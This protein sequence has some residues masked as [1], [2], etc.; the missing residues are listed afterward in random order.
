MGNQVYANAREI[1]CKGADGKSIASFPD[2]CF[3]PPQTPATPPGVP[4]PYPNTGMASD[5]TDGSKT[6]QISGQEIMLKDKSY[7]KKS[8]G[9]EA[10]SAPKKG[11][12]SSKI[13]G[14]VYF[15][16]WSMDVKFEGENVVRHWDVTT[17]N[18]GS[19]ANTPPWPYTDA[20]A[21]PG[22]PCAGQPKKCQMRPYRP[23]KCPE[24]KTGHHAIPVHCF[25]PP[26]ARKAGGQ[27]VYEGCGGYD[28]DKA[29]V[30]CV[31]GAGKE[32]THGRIHDTFDALEDDPKRKGVWSYKQ[33]ENAAV[34]SVCEETNCDEGCIRAQI[35]HNHKNEMDIKDDTTLRA[36]S[37]GKR[38]LERSPSVTSSGGAR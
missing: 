27:P 34:K 33:A 12:V 28:E 15:T 36:D 7:F 4:L 21:P 25:M 5:C 30:I 37:T 38:K 22:S 1:S 10:G 6:V 9:D 14:K 13:T 19:P 11:V 18:H 20:P 17:R 23:D 31:D 8:T 24:G 26:G 2:V 29:V 35:R 3:T 16:A 32:G